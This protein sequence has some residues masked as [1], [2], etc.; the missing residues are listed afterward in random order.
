MI[1]AWLLIIGG[2]VL[3]LVSLLILVAVTISFH[4]R[5]NELFEGRFGGRS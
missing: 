1:K 4:R 5:R 2:A 3:I